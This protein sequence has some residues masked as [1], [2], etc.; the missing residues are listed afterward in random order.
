MLVPVRRPGASVFFLAPADAAGS[1]LRALLTIGAQRRHLLLAKVLEALACEIRGLLDRRA[2][3]VGVRVDPLQVGL[4][5]RRLRGVVRAS[6]L[7]KRRRPSN[8]SNENENS[9]QCEPHIHHLP[10]TNQLL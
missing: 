1:G 6:R 5:P 3:L 8:Q 10:P 4:T 9:A 7:R 2:V